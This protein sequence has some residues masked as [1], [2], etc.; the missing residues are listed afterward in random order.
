MRARWYLR[1]EAEGSVDELAL[2]DGI[3][4]GDPAELTF[5]DGMHRLVAARPGIV[6][7]CHAYTAESADR[8]LLNARLT[9]GTR[10]T[11][12]HSLISAAVGLSHN[13]S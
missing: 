9:S 12:P 13:E 8:I 7:A 2:L 3:A 10:Q 6:T 4:L 11:N 1:G 5:A